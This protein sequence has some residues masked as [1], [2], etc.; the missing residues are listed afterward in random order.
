MEEEE[1]EVGST[2]LDICQ[3]KYSDNAFKQALAHDHNL[4][5]TLQKGLLP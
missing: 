3:Y 4:I 5:D 2:A 1:R